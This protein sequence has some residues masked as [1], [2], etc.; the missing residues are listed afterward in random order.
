MRPDPA[1][2]RAIL[3]RD[4][5]IIERSISVMSQ[6]AASVAPRSRAATPD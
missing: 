4:S 1:A 3:R 2:A 6:P 5:S